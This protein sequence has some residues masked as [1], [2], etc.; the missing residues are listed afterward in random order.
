MLT[1]SRF[2]GIE[3]SLRDY[4]LFNK[5]RG[6]MNQFECF[7][8]LVVPFLQLGI[9]RIENAVHVVDRVFDM[10]LLLES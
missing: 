9:E 4:A 8:D 7:E 3:V 1:T 2:D 5:V 10:L 6:V